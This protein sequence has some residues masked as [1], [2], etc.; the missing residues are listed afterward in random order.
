VEAVE[1]IRDGKKFPE[2]S[3]VITI[4]DGYRDFYDIAF[5]VLKSFGIPATIFLVTE[6]VAGNCWI[7]TDKARYI[8]TRTAVERLDFQINRTVFDKVLGDKKSRLTVAGSLNSE[9]KRLSD[10]EKEDYLTELSDALN[11]PISDQPPDEYSAL[12]WD[13]AKEL[14]AQGID[15]GSHTAT[16]PILTNVD[17]ARLVGELRDSRAA[18]QRELGQDTIHFCY[19]NGNVSQ[20][21]RDATEA[22]AYASAVTTEIRLCENT[23]DLFLIPRID[24]EPE[25]RRFVQATSG[26]DRVKTRLGKT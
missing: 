5:P 2:R 8:L 11:V 19:P 15:I 1:R 3:A 14:A 7:W 16:H 21:E 9:L 18:I 22:A 12:S 23:E 25:L 6:F 10:K 20:R 4:D 24:A 13:R 26:F 17:S